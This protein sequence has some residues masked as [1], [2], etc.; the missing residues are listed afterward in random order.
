MS[1][2][3]L[4]EDG[5]AVWLAVKVQPRASANEVAGMQGGELRIRLRAPPVD[6]A[7]NDELV[8][9]LAGLLDCPRRQVELVRGHRSRHKILRILGMTAGAVA[10]KIGL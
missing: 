1:A 10:S 8:R 2:P 4:R 7:A 6:D 5:E 9:F 3:F